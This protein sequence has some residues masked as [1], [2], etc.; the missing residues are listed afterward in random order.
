MFLYPFKKICFETD[1]SKEEIEQSLCIYKCPLCFKVLYA[2]EYFEGEV[3]KNKFSLKYNA[4][5]LGISGRADEFYNPVFY[6]NVYYNND[7]TII[8]I[9][10]GYEFLAVIYHL[11]FYGAYGLY[12]FYWLSDN[13]NFF[14][15]FDYEFHFFVLVFALVDL[16]I[17]NYCG[18]KFLKK[19]KEVLDIK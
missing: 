1:K 18:N 8:K 14:A 13:K 11:L 9:R 10:T 6:G 15:E 19:F 2:K 17:C 5:D 3:E 7:K 4:S 16:L 12:W